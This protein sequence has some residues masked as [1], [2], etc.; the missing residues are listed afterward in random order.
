MVARD[1]ERDSARGHRGISH[2]VYWGTR[3][4]APG[5]FSAA[6]E[7]ELVCMGATPAPAFKYIEGLDRMLFANVAR[8]P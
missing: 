8:F 3:A 5:H 1:R 7:E 4:C 6:R 2:A